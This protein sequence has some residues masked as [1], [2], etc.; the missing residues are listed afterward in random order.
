M[1]YRIYFGQHAS[2]IF[3][4]FYWIG[5][6]DQFNSQ[7]SAMLCIYAIDL[8]CKWYL[9]VWFFFIKKITNYFSF[10]VCFYTGLNR[11]LCLIKCHMGVYHLTFSVFVHPFYLI[12]IV[13][14]FTRW[15]RKYMTIVRGKK[16]L[17]SIKLRV[18]PFV[19]I[20]SISILSN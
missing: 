5:N 4:D 18:Y 13:V 3:M 17:V 8:W 14:M 2:W 16:W 9:C 15:H 1:Y 7:V 6:C 11:V 10:L 19:F 20:L 12:C